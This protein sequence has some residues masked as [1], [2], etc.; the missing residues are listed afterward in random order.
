MRVYF[1]YF[2]TKYV[3]IGVDMKESIHLIEFDYWCMAHLLSTN[4]ETKYNAV[5]VYW[6]NYIVGFIITL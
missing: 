4:F 2:I 5:C 1:Y 6:K 3:I